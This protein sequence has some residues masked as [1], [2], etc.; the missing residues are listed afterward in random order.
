MTVDLFSA[1]WCGELTRG[2][3]IGSREL[4]GDYEMM[5]VCPGGKAVVVIASSEVGDVLYFAC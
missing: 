3:K 4:G 2:V 5:A 1:S